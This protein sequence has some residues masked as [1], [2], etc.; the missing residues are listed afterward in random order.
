MGS[1][2][3]RI[4][5][6]RSSLTAFGPRPNACQAE[7]P[8]SGR[9]QGRQPP[10]AVARP[11]PAL[12]PAD[13]RSTSAQLLPGERPLLSPLPR[14]HRPAGIDARVAA[15]GPH[16]FAERCQRF[17]GAVCTA[18]TPQRP[19][20]TRADVRDDREASPLEARAEGKIVLIC[21]IVKRNSEESNERGLEFRYRDEVALKYRLLVAVF[22]GPL[23]PAAAASAG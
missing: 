13:R 18:L 5:V 9:G 11:A 23:T 6:N 20:A 3:L 10:K 19:I 21:G 22:Q 12:R 14:Q 1:E 7:R 16:D 15:P 2:P 4:A 17:V 8:V